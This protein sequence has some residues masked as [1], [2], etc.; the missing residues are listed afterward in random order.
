[1]IKESV[2]KVLPIAE[3]SFPSILYKYRQFSNEY[4]ERALFNREIYIPSANEFNDPYDSKIPFRYKEEDLTEDNIFK[5]CL[6]IAKAFGKDFGLTTEEQYHKKAYEMQQK[7][8]LKDVHH[9]DQFDKISY[10]QICT[11]FGIYCL[12]PNE[13]NLLMWSYYS[14]SHK[15]FCIGYNTSYLV[16]CGLFGM[17]GQVIY[18]DN[19]PKLPLFLTENDFPFLNILFTKWNIWNHENEYRLIHKYSRGKVFQLPQEAISEVVLG[20]QLSDEEQL[21]Y[22]SKIIEHL[23][24]V[25]IYQIKLNK[26]TLGLKKELLYDERL[27]VKFDKH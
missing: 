5:K 14:N 26:A 1:M 8:Y 2:G 11:D 16:K 7:G 24:D 18:D 17:G 6:S 22:Y 20:S 13:N 15:G 21:K 23:P 25:R 12:T 9:L 4:H 19:F 10:K 3:L 27:I